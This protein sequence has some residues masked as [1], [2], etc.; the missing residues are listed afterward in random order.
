MMTVPEAARINLAAYILAAVG[1]FGVLWLGL[2]PSLLGGLL[3]YNLVIFGARRLADVGI[4]PD[5]AKIILLVAITLLIVTGLTVG[6]VMFASYITEGRESIA[7][8]FQ[9]MADVVVTGSSY[10]PS[11]THVYLPANIEEWQVAAADWLRGNA[12]YFSVIGKDAVVLFVHLIVG[13][14]IGGMVAMH[15][16]MPSSRKAPLAHA[17]SERVELLGLA[18]RRIVFSQVR[19]SGLNTIL[20]GIFLAFIMPLLGYEL[21][22]VKTMIAVTFIVGLLPIIGNLISNTIIFLIALSVSGFAAMAA[23]IYL[24]VIHK[25]EYF[26]NAKII[27]S[28]IRARAW[29][30]LLALLVMDAAFGIAGLV[31]APIYYA[32]L[33]DELAAKK[34]I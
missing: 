15:P 29:E 16:A 5:A 19:I 23:L 13:M 9:R 28:Q 6:G 31:A 10:L 4:L 12:R 22:L 2:L 7:L 27:G 32:Y 14:I 8:L 20:T 24:I 1:L 17:M 30:I 18:F 21:P 34:L 11:W 26:V 3:I 33:K 25:L